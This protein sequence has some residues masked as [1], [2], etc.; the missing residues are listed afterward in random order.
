MI[1]RINKIKYLGVFSN[2]TRNSE[3]KDFEEKNIIYGWNYSGKTTISRLF[4]YLDKNEPI[5]ENYKDVEFE[6]ELLDGERITNEKRPESPVMIK[7][8]N[9]DFI[10]NNLHFDS[11]DEQRK[12]TGIKFAVGDTG[13]ILD[14]IK[15]KEKYIAKANSVIEHIRAPINSFR[16]VEN[17]FTDQ[18]RSLSDILNL[19]R[20]FTK[21]NIENYIKSWNE[22]NYEDFIINDESELSKIK[23]NATS[24]NTGV[25]INIDTV[26]KTSFTNIL[27][28]VKEILNEEPTK[29]DEDKL[30]SSDTDLYNWAKAGLRIYT[31]KRK[32]LNK[33]AFCG[34][35]LSDNRF[36]ELNAFYSNEAAK[37]KSKIEQLKIKI[38]SEKN[39]F[40]NLDWSKKSENDLAKS[41]QADF[42]QK[43]NEYNQILKAYNNL[44]EVLSE[45]LDEKAENYLFIPME[46]GAIDSSANDV[47]TN[48]INSVQEIFIQS[49]T[50]IN[51]FE[52]KQD[53]AKE[54]YK[55]HYIASFLIEKKYKELELRKNIAEN[56]VNKIQQ[57]IDEKNIE[58]TSLRD[59]LD[60][61]DKGKEELNNFIKLFLNREDLI[62]DVTDDK[63][64]V[65]NR[66][67]KFATHLS[68][69]EKTA[70]AFSHFMVMLKSLKD[71]G[72]L[73]DYIVFIDD[74]ISSLDANHIAQVYSL[75]NS[76]FFQKGLDAENPDKVCNCFRQLFI[77]THNFEFFSF[78]KDANYINKKKKVKEGEKTVDK[79]S[80]NYYFLKKINK[81]DSVIENIPKALSTYKSEYV[82]L[83][84]EI[85]R[86]RNENYPEER[87]YMI[88]NIVRR[89]LEIYT[90]MKLPGN[91]NEIANR[92]KILFE[93]K[94]TELKLLHNFS[95]FTS[96]E[97]ATKHSELILRIQ[98]VIEDLY[99]LLEKDSVHLES[100]REGIKN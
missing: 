61:V 99:K 79:P 14:Q 32:D 81:T 12:I 49:N 19:G 15:E 30:L 76:F 41:I 24:Q 9:S 51:E 17:K 85:E 70:I 68:D 45:K 71:E 73:K 42:I 64:F 48:W 7:V 78:L 91:R 5:D 3:L 36:Q 96:F 86:F 59:K 18:A 74:P 94:F 82:Y 43:K 2:Y 26:P 89:F 53:E 13:G 54:K 23:T 28:E 87:A 1:K 88:P 75:I 20:N 6:I 84:S 83:F 77:S 67:G 31:T 8:F 95:H 33:C 93:D 62:I 92:L 72:K 4:S 39:K 90:L 37:V 47:I 34:S 25:I 63:Y 60:S 66:N 55:E 56:R 22:K 40:T 27:K 58:I 11:N 38:D 100:L 35:D 21:R 97:R 98:D 52:Q 69:G 50:V 16:E 46:L 44:L 65:L 29:S 10:K 57:S 80:C